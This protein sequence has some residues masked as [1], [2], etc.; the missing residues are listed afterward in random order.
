MLLLRPLYVN[1]SVQ[2]DIRRAVLGTASSEDD[3]FELVLHTKTT[4]L[5]CSEDLGTFYEMNLLMRLKRNC[6]N[7]IV[8]HLD[9]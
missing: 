6:P 5:I 4:L 3:C 8:N 9:V 7:V 2:R 1:L